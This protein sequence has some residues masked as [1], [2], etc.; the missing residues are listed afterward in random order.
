MGLF[1]LHKL[2]DSLRVTRSWGYWPSSIREVPLENLKSYG[3]PEPDSL[4]AIL[5]RSKIFLNNTL[6]MSFF[7]ET[8]A[9]LWKFVRDPSENAEILL[10]KLFKPHSWSANGL[11]RRSRVNNEDMEPVSEPVVKPTIQVIPCTLSWTWNPEMILCSVACPQAEK[12]MSIPT[13]WEPGCPLQS[14]I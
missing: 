6:S 11:R 3:V 12:Y 2:W 5:S 10:S 7:K 9:L 13:P 1:W 4:K 14:T 8:C